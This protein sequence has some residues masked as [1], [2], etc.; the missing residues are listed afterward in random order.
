[1]KKTVDYFATADGDTLLDLERTRAQERHGCWSS[2]KQEAKQKESDLMMTCTV[3]FRSLREGKRGGA[4]A[5]FA[6]VL[7]RGTF[8]AD[9]QHA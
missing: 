8:G 5:K 6:T 7:S 3:G 2:A 4:R 1:M 9:H